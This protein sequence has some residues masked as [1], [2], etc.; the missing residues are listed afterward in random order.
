MCYLLLIIKKWNQNKIIL[1][2]YHKQNNNKDFA[3]FLVRTKKNKYFNISH[4]I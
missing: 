3:L 2:Y 4:L 1:I